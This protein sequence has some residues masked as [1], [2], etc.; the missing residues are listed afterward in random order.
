MI[1]KNVAA[2][3]P[4]EAIHEYIQRFETE[5]T[6]VYRLHNLESDR[7]LF[8]KLIILYEVV[9][10]VSDE[11]IQFKW[12]WIVPIELTIAGEKYFGKPDAER[13]DEL[14]AECKLIPLDHHARLVHDDLLAFI[15][16]R[17]SF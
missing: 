7:E 14:I 8:N 15:E 11:R 6:K 3:S 16:S 1:Q 10:T 13:I 12:G 2:F 9:N 4:S 17:E 5:E